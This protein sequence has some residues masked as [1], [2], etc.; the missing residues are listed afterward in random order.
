[1]QGVD[2]RLLAHRFAVAFHRQA[3]TSRTIRSELDDVPGIG[4]AKRRRLLSVF[5]AA[6]RRLAERGVVTRSKAEP[7]L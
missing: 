3:R 5:G 1:M 2:H 4:P 6:V 7:H